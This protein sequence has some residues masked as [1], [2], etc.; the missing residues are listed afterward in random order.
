MQARTFFF[1]SFFLFSIQKKMSFEVRTF[2]QEVS[3]GHVLTMPN[4]GT[5]LSV[6]DPF[7]APFNDALRERYVCVW[8]EEEEG[9]GLIDW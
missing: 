7:L 9:D 8:R 2:E 4:D 3:P 1:S 6:I 5:G